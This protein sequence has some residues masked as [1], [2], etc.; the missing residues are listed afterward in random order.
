MISTAN[1]S[2]CC[3][4]TRGRLI[5][6]AWSVSRIIAKLSESASRFSSSGVKHQ[7]GSLSF[8][9]R[10]QRASASGHFAAQASRRFSTG[11]PIGEETSMRLLREGNERDGM[12]ERDRDRQGGRV[13]REAGP[14]AD[15][16]KDS[17]LTAGGYSSAA[18]DPEES[19]FGAP[20]VG[21]AGPGAV[22]RGAEE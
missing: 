1:R 2:T 7:R 12:G 6:T 10:L 11:V 13:G 14:V 4:S 20:G 15:L 21:E 19:G 22:Q 9:N 8:V 5:T 18:V 3:S 17:G 16:A